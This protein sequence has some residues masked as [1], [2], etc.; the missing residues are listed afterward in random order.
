MMH[1]VKY[2]WLWVHIRVHLAATQET[3]FF[4]QRVHRGTRKIRLLF[5]KVYTFFFIREI[6]VFYPQNNE[7]SRY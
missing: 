7:K 4:H 6:G 1:C 5:F 3:V 2:S